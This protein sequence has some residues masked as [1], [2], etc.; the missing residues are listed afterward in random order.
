MVRSLACQTDLCG[1]LSLLLHATTEPPLKASAC[2]WPLDHPHVRDSPLPGRSLLLRAKV[3]WNS[4]LQSSGSGA[5]WVVNMVV[6]SRSACTPPTPHHIVGLRLGQRRCSCSWLSNG[7]KCGPG[8]VEKLTPGSNWEGKKRQK[9]F[10]NNFVWDFLL[11]CFLSFSC[12]HTPSLGTHSALPTSID[13]SFSL[14][15][16]AKWCQDMRGSFGKDSGHLPFE[17]WMSFA[18]SFFFLGEKHWR[19]EVFQLIRLGLS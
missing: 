16:S 14:R 12:I 5:F 18:E 15:L 17:K 19:L 3:K 10:W 1:L 4:C 13:Y 8:G 6:S 7:I 2:G 9:S 11:S